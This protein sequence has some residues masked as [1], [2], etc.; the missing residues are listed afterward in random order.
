MNNYIKKQRLSLGLTQSTLAKR[1]NI[2]RPY[3]S[4]IENN[5]TEPSGK[6]V[7]R[8]AK[9]LQCKA[10]EIFFEE[11]V[12]HVIQNDSESEAV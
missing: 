9:H 2:S 4:E 5:K 10:E 12:L 1:V 8:I 6:V 7:L 11:D 3:L